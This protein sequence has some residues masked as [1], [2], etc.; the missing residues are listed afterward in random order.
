MAR[1]Q[2]RPTGKAYERR[3]KDGTVVFD[4]VVYYGRDAETNKQLR[5]WQ[6]GYES[7]DDA[8]RAVDL[9][10]VDPEWLPSDGTTVA[11]LVTEY[12]DS[13]AA[14][15]KEVTTINRYRG[16]LRNNVTPFIGTIRIEELRP[17]HLDDLYQR[18]RKGDKKK[19]GLSS[20]S[21]KHIHSLLNATYRWAMWK[22][23]VTNNPVERADV[24]ARKRSRGRAAQVEEVRKIIAE[25]REHRMEAPLLFAIATGM[26]RGEIVALREAHVDHAARLAKVCEALVNGGKDNVFVKSTK[27]DEP[28]E[29][30]LNDLAVK[31]LKIAKLNRAKWKLLAGEAWV[32]SDYIFIDELGRRL[33]PNVLTDAFRR[34]CER[35]GLKYRL[36]DMRHTAAS[37][38]LRAGKDIAAVQRVL[39]HSSASTTL[40]V[41][42]H[43]LD[44]ATA[45]AVKALDR[46]L[47]S[48][49]GSV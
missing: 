28:R 6:R 12:I 45:D 38:M 31:A 39:G 19:R 34:A 43:V 1:H 16:I 36:H 24:P 13:V 20:T 46:M 48:G 23:R 22:N 8:L 25:L 17:K 33:H 41:Y 42:G 10:K 18:L 32:G 27:T 15:D 5:R 7:L 35:I 40:D 2:F 44:G 14:R 26:R 11:D 21:I 29:V 3:L 9:M 49:E 37:F 30:P 47:A 4:A